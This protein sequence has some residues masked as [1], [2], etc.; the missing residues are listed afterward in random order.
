M[1][2]DQRRTRRDRPG[3]RRPGVRERSPFEASRSTDE[4]RNRTIGFSGGSTDLFDRFVSKITAGAD[5]PTLFRLDVYVRDICSGCSTRTL[6][7]GEAIAAACEE[8]KRSPKSQSCREQARHRP[9]KLD[10]LLRP[11]K[12]ED[13]TT[14]EMY[15]TVRDLA[16]WLANEKRNSR[17]LERSSRSRPRCS[18]TF[19]AL[20]P[21]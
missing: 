19:L 14:R 13:A 15:V 16:L 6:K 5:S 12:R 17:A 1:R 8:I 10:F 21:K 3:A 9:P 18:A 7:R 2:C 11:A 20:R 4:G